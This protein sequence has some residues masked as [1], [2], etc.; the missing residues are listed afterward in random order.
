MA[1]RPI[2]P[3]APSEAPSTQPQIRARPR[4]APPES[5]PDVLPPAPDPEPDPE[6]DDQGRDYNVGYGKPPL[7]TR[8]KP[9]QSGN[10]KGRPK[11]AKGLNTLA[12]SAL[13]E[14]VKVRTANGEKR[15]TRIEALLHKLMEL[16][17]KGNGAALANLLKIYAVAVPDQQEVDGVP[18]QPEDLTATDLEILEELRVLL[19][20]DK[21]VAQ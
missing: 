12:R 21:E 6:P 17:M 7:E 20:D 4:P 15:M 11:R 18:H 9:G 10:P 2:A 1:I 3:R 14:K 16:A 19:G 13:T 8:F 5:N